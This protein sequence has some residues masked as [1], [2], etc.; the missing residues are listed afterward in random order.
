[1][2]AM[3]LRMHETMKHVKV[4]VKCPTYIL[5]GLWLEAQLES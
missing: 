4:F 5:T 3:H 2:Q 1:M